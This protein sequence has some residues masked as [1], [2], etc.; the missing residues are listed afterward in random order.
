MAYTY[1]NER[2]SRAVLS[3]ARTWQNNS[4]AAS[5]GCNIPW[6][7]VASIAS[8]LL[9]KEKSPQHYE[10]RACV[11]AVATAVQI[12]DNARGSILMAHN[13]DLKNYQSFV[14]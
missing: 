7:H 12:N 4:H 5:H 10:A 2:A 9:S 14:T 3:R 8:E 13:N 11:V 6:R 1:F